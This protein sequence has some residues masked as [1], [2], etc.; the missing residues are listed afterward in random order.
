MQP[1]IRGYETQVKV[2]MILVVLFLVSANLIT[3]TFLTRSEDLLLGEARARILAATA[4]I[5][6][7][8]IKGGLAG[9]RLGEPGGESRVADQLLDLARAH[10]ASLV[11]VLDRD[12][13]I[14]VS[15]QS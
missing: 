12:G 9:A 14:I 10:G 13:L 2:F 7:E 4:A 5:G 3:V 8:V 15:S 1:L 6:R 11:E